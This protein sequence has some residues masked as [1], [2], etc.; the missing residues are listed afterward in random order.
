MNLQKWKIVLGVVVA[1]GVLAYN[2]CFVVNMNEM[3]VITQA[4]ET[5]SRAHH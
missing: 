5:G 1:L 3:A 2:A 4:G